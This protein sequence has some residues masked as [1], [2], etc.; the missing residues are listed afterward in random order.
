MS[1]LASRSNLRLR[2]ELD[3]RVGQPVY[4]QI[5]GQLQDQALTGRLLVGTQ[6]P[7]VRELA[8]RLGVNFNTVA[9]AYRLLA[10]AGT[11]STQPGRGTFLLAGSRRRPGL[12][13]HQF[14][15]DYIARARQLHFSDAQIAAALERALGRR[16]A[17]SPAG[18]NHE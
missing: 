1:A 5:V 6:L 10:R 4:L 3:P 17:S 15:A 16:P 7:T 2:V 13:L 9:R 11:V 12:A 18:D 14:A 8:R